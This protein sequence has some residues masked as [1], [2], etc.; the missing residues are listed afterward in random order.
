MKTHTQQLDKED[1]LQL[2]L[3]ESHVEVDLCK[4]VLLIGSYLL[5]N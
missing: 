2:S 3:L 5:F 1:F 4:L